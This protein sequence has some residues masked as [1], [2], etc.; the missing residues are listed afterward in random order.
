ML[1]VSNGISFG[2]RF[3]VNARKVRGVT[4]MLASPATTSYPTPWRFGYVSILFLSFF[5][6]HHW[7]CSL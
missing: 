1:F 5:P 2:L 6:R 7:M 4:E 3:T